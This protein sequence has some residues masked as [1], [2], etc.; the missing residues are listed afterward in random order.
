MTVEQQ[1]AADGLT[2][3]ARPTLR[4]SCSPERGCTP[5]WS[6][7]PPSLTRSYTVPGCRGCP[8]TLPAIVSS[9]RMGFQTLAIE[10]RR[11][12][13]GSSSELSGES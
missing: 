4:S 1:H 7:S 3:P 12:R 11:R 6:G 2:L 8:T 5:K 10:Q 13:F 9:L